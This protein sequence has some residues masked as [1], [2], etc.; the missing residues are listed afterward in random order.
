MNN[1]N[2][3]IS[4]LRESLASPDLAPAA[5][6]ILQVRLEYWLNKAKPVVANYRDITRATKSS[7]RSRRMAAR[8]KYR[9]VRPMIILMQT[10]GLKGKEIVTHLKE[11][12]V[13]NLRGKPYGLGGIQY[14][15]RET[16]CAKF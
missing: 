14:I 7:A 2:I 10:E 6:R 3:I 12:G 5:R 8:R 13:T 15:M 16:H 1:R 9:V 11:A 4:A